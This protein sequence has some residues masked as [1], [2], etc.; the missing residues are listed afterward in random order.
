MGEAGFERVRRLF[1][2]DRMVDETL[3]IYERVA[4]R[5][6][7]AG[8][9]IRRRRRE[10]AQALHPKV[11]QR[12]VVLHGIRRI[13]LPERR[14][15]GRRHA[16]AGDA[17]GVSRGTGRRDSRA[18]RAGRRDAPVTRASRRRGR[19][20]HGAPSTGETGSDVCR[21]SLRGQREERVHAGRA[22]RLPYTGR[23][24]TARAR[25]P[26]D[27]SAVPISGDA[28]SSPSR[29]HCSSEPLV[30]STWRKINSRATMSAA[31]PPVHERQKRP[32]IAA[33][34]EVAHEGRR[35]GPHRCKHGPH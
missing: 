12:E 21:R 8:T 13:D 33:R 23:R 3:A 9:G 22:S 26:N 32:G 14:C 20:R 16:P 35:R 4:G 18:R 15:D 10:A 17:Y 25:A 7:A 5:R 1:S 31:H 27:S 11:T 28:A 34:R 30:S 2:V 24:S 29:K 6:R 19:R